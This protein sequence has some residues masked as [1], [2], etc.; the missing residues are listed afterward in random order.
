MA[1]LYTDQ[2][3]SRNIQHIDCL[4]INLSSYKFYFQYSG[5]K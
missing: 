4:Y 3:K 5:M 1:H 2:R